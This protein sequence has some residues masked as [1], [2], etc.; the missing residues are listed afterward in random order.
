MLMERD[1]P[2]VLGE[3]SWEEVAMQCCGGERVSSR[4]AGGG[5]EGRGKRDAM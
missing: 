5:Q 4:A 1:G 2:A 3:A